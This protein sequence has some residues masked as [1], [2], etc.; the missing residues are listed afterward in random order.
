MDLS[1]P[2]QENILPNHPAH[3]KLTK[4][5]DLPIS[6]ITTI[7][8]DSNAKRLYDLIWKRAI[9]SQMAEAQLEK[10]IATIGIST[11]P[12]DLIATSNT[13]IRRIP[14]SIS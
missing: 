1:T 4:L 2:K 3:R 10:T 8:G 7:E 14:K 6:I 11:T 5:S 13:K 12:E 9:A